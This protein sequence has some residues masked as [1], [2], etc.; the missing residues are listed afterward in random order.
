MGGDL[1]GASGDAQPV[2]G[3]SA[4]LIGD[5]A[6]VSH[7]GDDMFFGIGPHLYRRPEEE[8]REVM[9]CLQSD[10]LEFPRPAL[11]SFVL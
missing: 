11:A 5:A 9:L 1:L 3:P 6:A 2:D 7:T 10:L 4:R 8:L